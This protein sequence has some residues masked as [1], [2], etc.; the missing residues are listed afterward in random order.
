MI[1]NQKIICVTNLKAMYAAIVSNARENGM[2]IDQ[3]ARDLTGT[4]KED[5]TKKLNMLQTRFTKRT[6]DFIGE[7]FSESIQAVFAQI[8][9]ESSKIGE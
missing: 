7:Q 9:K 8:L 2:S 5:E 3:S 4:Y 6:K 1:E